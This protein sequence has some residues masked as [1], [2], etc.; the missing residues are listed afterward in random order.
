MSIPC[1]GV[2]RLLSR[3]KEACAE[4]HH[5]GEAY[6]GVGGA[7]DFIRILLLK[8]GTLCHWYVGIHGGKWKAL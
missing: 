6:G 8:G 4:H 2:L 1:N 3:D 7:A 5:R